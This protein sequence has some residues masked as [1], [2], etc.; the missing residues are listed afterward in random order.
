[1]INL[2]HPYIATKFLFHMTKLFYKIVKYYFKWIQS[3]KSYSFSALASNNCCNFH[4]SPIL[5]LIYFIVINHHLHFQ[6]SSNHS[7]LFMPIIQSH[8]LFYPLFLNLLVCTNNLKY[9]STKT[10]WGKNTTTFNKQF[11]SYF[12]RKILVYFDPV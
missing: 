4:L 9:Y 5:Q 6:Q 2:T 1:M 12:M 3:Y 11:S 10:T 7:Y 8:Q